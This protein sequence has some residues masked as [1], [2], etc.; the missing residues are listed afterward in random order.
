MSRNCRAPLELQELRRRVCSTRHHNWRRVGSRAA[1]KSKRR[2]EVRNGFLPSSP[3]CR[4]WTAPLPAKHPN[5][6]TSKSV[7]A[8]SF[9]VFGSAFVLFHLLFFLLLRWPTCCVVRSSSPAT[10]AVGY[11]LDR[12]NRRPLLLWSAVRQAGV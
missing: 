3:S 2:G 12:V 4:L 5:T 1:A 6:H 8:F 7:L 10:R 11:P 9:T